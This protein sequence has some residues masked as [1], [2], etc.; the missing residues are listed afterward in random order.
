MPAS[1]LDW[2]INPIDPRSFKAE[3]WD[4]RPLIVKRN[5][6]TYY[7]GLLSLI[8]VD[9]ILSASPIRSSHIRAIEMGRRSR[10]NYLR[11]VGCPATRDHSIAFALNIAKVRRSY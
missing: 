6:P 1:S 9:H 3:Y 2:L 4:K 11:A 8:D 7:D 10:Y 5:D